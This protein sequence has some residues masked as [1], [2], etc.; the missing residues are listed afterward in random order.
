MV[1]DGKRVLLVLWVLRL[2][3][4]HILANDEACQILPHLRQ[5]GLL[6]TC[7]A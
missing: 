5:P 1:T 2:V 3:A 6:G 4:C 7:M